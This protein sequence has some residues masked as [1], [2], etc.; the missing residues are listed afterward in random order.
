MKAGIIVAGLVI[1]VLGGIAAYWFSNTPKEVNNS[2]PDSIENQTEGKA[3]VGD[4]ISIGSN[5]SVGSDSTNTSGLA[6]NYIT[7]LGADAY[8]NSTADKIVLFFYADWCPT[9]RPIDMEFKDNIP[10]IP[11]GIEI[12]RVN[13]NDQ[14]TD[15]QEKALA[16]KYGVTYQHTFVQI[17]KD[18]N[19]IT[20]WNGGGLEKLL[21]S[22]K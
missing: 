3:E 8:K 22:I 1:L 21:S 17:D 12:Y 4:I 14:D 19:E 18:G 2:T 10:K 16:K 20:K 7:G 13:Y 9:C 15:E 6:G 11:A 5:L